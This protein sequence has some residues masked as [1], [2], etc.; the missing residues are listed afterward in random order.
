MPAITVPTLVVH[1]DA[2]VSLPLEL[3]G[4]RSAQ[5]VPGGRLEVYEGAPHGLFLTPPC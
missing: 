2:D 3:C 1:G 4:A 5:L